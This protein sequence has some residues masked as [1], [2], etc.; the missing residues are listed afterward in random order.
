MGTVDELCYGQRGKSL[1][2][3]RQSNMAGIPEHE[4]HKLLNLQSHWNWQLYCPEGDRDPD[5]CRYSCID[6]TRDRDKDMASRINW[7]RYLA[8]HCTSITLMEVIQLTFHDIVIPTEIFG[9]V[10]VGDSETIRLSPV[11]DDHAT[12]VDTV[13]TN[14]RSA[15][16]TLGIR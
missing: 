7:W 13:A 2:D 5:L 15:A 6:I 12:I 9:E 8:S 3:E 1:I 16:T 14:P 4:R 11:A 10:E